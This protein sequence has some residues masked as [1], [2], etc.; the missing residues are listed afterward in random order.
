MAVPPTPPDHWAETKVGKS[1]CGLAYCPI[2]P[3]SHWA[4]PLNSSL[5]RSPEASFPHITEGNK[6]CRG[7]P[8]CSPQPLLIVLGFMLLVFPQILADLA[9]DAMWLYR[10]PLVSLLLLFMLLV[11]QK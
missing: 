7:Q 2:Y 6:A 8:A 4:D 3:P 10:S 5:S 9:M 11:T 1:A